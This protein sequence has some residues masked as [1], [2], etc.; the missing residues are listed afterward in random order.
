MAIAKLFLLAV[1]LSSCGEK[2]EPGARPIEPKEPPKPVTIP[3]GALY[4]DGN[5]EATYELITRCGYNYETP[6]AS[7]SHASAPFRHIRQV[8]DARLKKPVF[9]FYLHINEDDDRGLPNVKDRQRNEI[10]TDG[11]SPASLVAQQ[12]ETM[13]YSW[14][15]KLPLFIKTTTKFAHIHQLKGIDNKEGTAD[16]G[17]PL[18]T[19]TLRS[20]SS[21]GQQFQIIH[22]SPTPM[23]SQATYLLKC[24]L[25]DF[26][27][28]WVEVEEKV[29]FDAN[30]A[31]SVSIKRI[32]DKKVL[33]K[34][35]N[36]PLHLWRDG[37]TG[38]R[39]KWGLYRSFGD[40]G[41]LKSQLR[42]EVLLF[43]DFLIVKED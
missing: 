27:G 30:G 33:A 11:H 10:K 6:D 19:F 34:I 12:G 32:S 15:F 29:K 25:N 7:G 3:A 40:K 36:M 37:T 26:L 42:D 39:P 17:L 1:L 24:D 2:V 5:D 13:H 28:E 18:I 4:A 35:E 23:G 31:Y 38:L 21:G 9:Q 22:T 14:K 20:T 43:A 16:V 8:Q 41:S